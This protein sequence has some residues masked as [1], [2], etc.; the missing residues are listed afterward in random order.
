MADLGRPRRWRRGCGKGP[1][2]S[3]VVAQHAVAA[4]IADAAELVEER[5]GVGAASGPSLVEVLE[6]GVED[7]G[8][9]AGSGGGDE[10]FDVGGPGVA[11]DGFAGQAEFTDDGL[12][13]ATF[14]AQPLD[15]LETVAG[16]PGQTALSL[17]GCCVGRHEFRVERRLRRCRLRRWGK[18]ALMAGDGFLDVL[19]EVVP[20]VPPVGDLD[21]VRSAAA[22]R[23][24][25]GASAVAAD[26]LRARIRFQPGGERVRFAVWQHVDWGAGVQVDQDGAV[27]VATPEREVVDAEHGHCAG[28]AFR[29][30]ADQPQQGVA[31]GLEPETGG[32][33]GG[34]PSRQ[35]QPERLQNVPSR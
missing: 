8:P 6:V 33:P 26:H 35:G 31:P 2:R 28:L 12:D 29:D 4:E 32:E 19:G 10:V 7:A 22:G 18:A 16:A 24:G 14:V 34:R 11:A 1:Q 20:E 9:G 3:D 17:G 27:A 15:L 5:L 13:A 25:V 21:G 23:F 30:R